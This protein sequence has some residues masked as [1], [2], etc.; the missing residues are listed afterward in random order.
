MIS[1]VNKSKPALLLLLEDLHEHLYHL[2]IEK[3]GSNKYIRSE[4]VTGELVFNASEDRKSVI[5]R[6]LWSDGEVEFIKS[7]PFYK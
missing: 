4:D 5:V 6:M 2:G 1:N 3:V 7:Y